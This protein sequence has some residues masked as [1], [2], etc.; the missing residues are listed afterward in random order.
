MTYIYLNLGVS[1]Y[2]DYLC[3]SNCGLR[4][5]VLGL[6]RFVLTVYLKITSEG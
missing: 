4:V 5:I 1:W 6:R 3:S 2:V